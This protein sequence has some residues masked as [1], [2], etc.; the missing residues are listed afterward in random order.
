MRL[1]FWGL[2]AVLLLRVFVWT[3]GISKSPGV[4]MMEHDVVQ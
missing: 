1:V 2:Q 3:A 4:K